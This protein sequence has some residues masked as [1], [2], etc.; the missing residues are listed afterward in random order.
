MSFELAQLQIEAV[1]PLENIKDSLDKA[2]KAEHRE[3]F[4]KTIAEEYDNVYKLKEIIQETIIFDEVLQKEVTTT[5]VIGFDYLDDAPTLQE[6]KDETKTVL[7]GTETLMDDD[8][9]EYESEIFEE[10]PIRPYVSQLQS[11]IDAL[12]NTNDS[13]VAY[14]LKL[15]QEAINTSIDSLTVTTTAGNTFDATLTA[16]QN[17]ADGILASETLAMTQTTWRLADNSEV[18]IDIVELREAHA[19]ALQAYAKAKS[20]GT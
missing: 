2:Y 6:Y 17:M 7:I 3:A 12:V 15:S 18:M 20:I 14:Q 1:M 8:G 13:L 4:D 10:Q 9:V 5:E 19:L 11:D 16:R